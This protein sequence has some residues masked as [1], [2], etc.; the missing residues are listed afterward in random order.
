[1]KPPTKQDKTIYTLSAEDILRAIGEEPLSN[2]DTVWVSTNAESWGVLKVR[3]EPLVV[4]V[5]VTR[6][7]GPRG[8]T[9]DA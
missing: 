4:T 8:E 6:E 9:G 1:M 2:G 7:V 3:H 5:S